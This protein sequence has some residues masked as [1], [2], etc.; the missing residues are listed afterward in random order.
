MAPH[1]P[2]DGP[3]RF[4]PALDGVPGFAALLVLFGHTAGALGASA[5]TP[6]VVAAKVRV[7]SL[8]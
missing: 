1:T 3:L 7:T 5:L 6:A 2:S 4:I 8:L